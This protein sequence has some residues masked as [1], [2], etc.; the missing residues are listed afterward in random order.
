V[1]IV[2]LVLGLRLIF[3]LTDPASNGP[4][5]SPDIFPA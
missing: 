5:G 4:A 2:V 3:H 1:G